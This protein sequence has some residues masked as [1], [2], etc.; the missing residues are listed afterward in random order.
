MSIKP[1]IFK[2]I[3]PEPERFRVFVDQRGFEPRTSSMPWKRSSQLS[4][5][6]FLNFKIQITNVKS[7]PKSQYQNINIICN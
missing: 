2:N 3:N 4:Y 7:N 5:W 1:E 6:P